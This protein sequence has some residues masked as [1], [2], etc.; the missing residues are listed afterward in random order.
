[1]KILRNPF[2]LKCKETEMYWNKVL[3]SLRLIKMK[4]LYLF[5]CFQDRG[6]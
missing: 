5:K 2:K 4:K 3:D 1:M 6:K